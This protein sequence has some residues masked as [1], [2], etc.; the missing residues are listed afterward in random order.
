VLIFFA[1][2]SFAQMDSVGAKESINSLTPK[3][4]LKDTSAKIKR[5]YWLSLGLGGNNAGPGYLFRFTYAKGIESLGIQYGSFVNFN[6]GGG[7]GDELREISAYY[8]RQEYED[9]LGRIGFGVGYFW[10]WLSGKKINTIAPGIQ[11][12][13]IFH[14]AGFGVGVLGSIN[15]AP[16]FLAAGIS[17]NI[18]FGKFQ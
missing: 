4:S 10:G 5:L 6:L 8:G 11:G 17:L 16:K 1:S 13:V 2:Q 12:E 14:G 7:N 18:H 9:V 15:A 3:D